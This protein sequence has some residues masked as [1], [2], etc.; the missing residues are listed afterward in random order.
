[1]KKIVLLLILIL[2]SGCTTGSVTKEVFEGPFKVTNVVDG[3][4]K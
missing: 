3:N 1:M 2:I 4:P